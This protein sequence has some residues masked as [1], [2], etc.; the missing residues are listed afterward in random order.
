L[1]NHSKKHQHPTTI[2]GYI[3]PAEK[4]NVRHPTLATKTLIN[5]C[6][7]KNETETAL[8]KGSILI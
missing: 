3:L 2:L 5:K 1:L 6:Q 8:P 7:A 4:M